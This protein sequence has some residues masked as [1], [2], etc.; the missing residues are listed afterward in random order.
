MAAQTLGLIVRVLDD[1][2]KAIL[3]ATPWTSGDRDLAQK[4]EAALVRSLRFRPQFVHR[5]PVAK[6]SA[7]L[8]AR[9]DLVDVKQVAR[10]TLVAYH[11]TYQVPLLTAFLDA[12]GIPHESGNIKASSSEYVIPSDAALREIINSVASSFGVVAVFVYLETAA[13]LMAGDWE[14]PRAVLQELMTEAS[15]R[16]N[17]AIPDEPDQEEGDSEQDN[18][19]TE[20]LTT[21]DRVLIKTI[22][23]A[24]GDS[25]GSL[26]VDQA[27]EVIDELLHLS[28]DRH[29]TYFHR[30]FLYALLDRPRVEGFESN[31]SRRAWQLAGEL[32]ALARR[33]E[34]AEIVLRQDANPA[35]FN[36]M[37]RHPSASSSG[38]RDLFEALWLQGY[39]A[40]AAQSLTPD[41]IRRRGPAFM[42]LLLHRAVEQ[43]HAQQESDA[44]RI[45]QL[46]D[47]AIDDPAREVLGERF[48]FEV[49][50]RI[51]QCLRVD[52]SFEQAAA[53]FETLLTAAPPEMVAE[54]HTD[55]GLCRGQFRR[56]GDVRIPPSEADAKAVVFRIRAGMAHFD[57]AVRSRGRRASSR[58]VLGVL[59]LLEGEYADARMHLVEAY[60]GA[61]A[62]K[63]LL[64][65]YRSSG[66]YGRIL[67]AYALSIFLDYAEV[68]FTF[69]TELLRE[70]DGHFARSEWPEWLLARAVEVAAGF[71][72]DGARLIEFVS[73]QFPAILDQSS[74]NVALLDR[75]ALLRSVIERNSADDRRPRSKRWT[76]N[77]AL[78][79]FHRLHGDHEAASQVLDRLEELALVDASLRAS[80]LTLLEHP[81]RLDPLWD[82]EDILTSRIQLLQLDCRL[83]EAAEALARLGHRYIALR[84]FGEAGNVVARLRSC[85]PE[86]KYCDAIIGRLPKLSS[87]TVASDPSGN[88]DHVQRYL[89][90]RTLSVLFVGGG[91]R[92]EKHDER[93][94]ETLGSRFGPNLT[95]TF[96]HD[97]WSHNTGRTFAALKNPVRDSDVIVLS[98]L[99]RT[100]LGRS[101]R[102]LINDEGKMWA[103]CTMDGIEGMSRAIETAIRRFVETSLDAGISP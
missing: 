52:G 9:F 15:D 5:Q 58:Y 84:R 4:A 6:K 51:T 43:I 97:S 38:A 85:D 101:L 45:L 50:R 36:A 31:E 46:L 74:Q 76:D 87:E 14:R 56:L 39:R 63:A 64:E 53:E 16:I 7:W 57:E 99:M 25:E 93:V 102:R 1:E 18:E 26:T 86:S 103:P 55:R 54:I 23:A 30:G 94:I 13:L 34:Y 72:G 21:L 65:R 12:C 92:L 95:L 19:R 41:L 90:T 47:S 75:S 48:E 10:D 11:L 69:A 80:F 37:L 71:S 20:G 59:S 33:G 81:S 82:D 88:D 79:E 8:L 66:V 3:G 28:V 73:E 96:E 42:N 62:D 35:E 78:L 44:R 77:E 49:Q 61:A 83:D 2:T 91:E 100:N 32:A 27:D 24:V 89:S 40:R 70:A 22:I 67:V 68:H 29:Q 17:T 98:D 60:E